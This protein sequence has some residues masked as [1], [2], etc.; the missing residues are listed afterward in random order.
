MFNLKDPYLVILVGHPL[1][2]KSTAISKYFPET[3]IIS[4]D[5]IV[6]ELANTTDYNKAFNTVNHKNVDKILRERMV[7]NSDNRIN[8]ILDMTHMASKRRK[9]NLSFFDKDFY[10]LCVVF[11]HLTKDEWFKRNEKRKLEENK[12]ISWGIVE[13]MIKSYQVPQKEE[14]FN[15]IVHI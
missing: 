8:T 3:N 4:R 13:N 10:R 14:G 1:V 2:G 15:K 12:D 5:S 9:Y 7:Y 11:S 6:L